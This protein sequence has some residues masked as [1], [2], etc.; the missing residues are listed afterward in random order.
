MI[1]YLKF[2]YYIYI[3]MKFIKWLIK[4]YKDTDSVYGDLAGDVDYDINENNLNINT[5]TD[6]KKRLRILNIQNEDIFKILDNAYLIY[7]NK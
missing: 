2:L 6:L 4:N 3:N 1:V 5:Y 7:K